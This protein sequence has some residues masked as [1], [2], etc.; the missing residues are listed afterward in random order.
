MDISVFEDCKNLSE[1]AR[2]LFNSDDYTSREKIKQI[3]IECGVDDWKTWFKN[4]NKKYCKCCG[5][6][7]SGS[8]T[9]YCSSSCAAKINNSL[10]KKRQKTIH[11]C[12]NCGKELSRNHRFCSN[13]CQCEYEY[14]EI[15]NKWLNG[16]HVGCSKNGEISPFLRKYLLH[17][18]EHKC[19]NCG[20]DK[21]NPYTGNDILEIHHIDG[22]CYNNRPENLQVLCPNC[23]ALTENYGRR[24]F[25]STRKLRYNKE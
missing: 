21:K 15:V 8:Q 18:K 16:E 24:N 13:A 12:V 22:D 17:L 3:L 9:Q 11:Y 2:L 23:H 4:K 5:K 20:Y 1:C 25:N 7:L 10:Y 6:E 14:N 19:E